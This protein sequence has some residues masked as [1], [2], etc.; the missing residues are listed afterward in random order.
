M[1]GR[2]LAN[3]PRPR[4]FTQRVPGPHARRVGRLEMLATFLAGVLSHFVTFSVPISEWCGRLD[5]F[6]LGLET[7]PPFQ[8]A[9]L[10][11]FEFAG[12]LGARLPLK[13]T[14]Q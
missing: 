12:Q 6:G 9:L 2:W 10:G 3:V 14:A 13:H 4:R 11:Q 1:G 7:M 5:S 8:D